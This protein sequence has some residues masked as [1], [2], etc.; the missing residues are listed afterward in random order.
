MTQAQEIFDQIEAMSPPD[1]LRF[2]AALL[3]NK[4][5]EIAKSIIDRVS[6][7]LGAALLF[8]RYPKG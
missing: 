8:A 7:E 5:P 3:E 4:K 1:K 6:A 2:A